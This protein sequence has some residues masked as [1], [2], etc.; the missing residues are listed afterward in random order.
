MTWGIILMLAG[1]SV[2]LRTS[3]ALMEHAYSRRVVE[4]A[5]TAVPA[6]LAAFIFVLLSG[7]PTVHEQPVV[8]VLALGTAAVLAIRRAPLLV[9]LLS[10]AGVA[11]IARLF[12]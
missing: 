11:A 12:V 1:I 5:T 2:G 10:A 9:V 4:A 6:M 3:G 8:P 7:D